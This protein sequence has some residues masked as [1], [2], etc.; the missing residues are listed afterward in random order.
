MQRVRNYMFFP[1]G[2]SMF[3]QD[4]FSCK[5][6]AETKVRKVN[7]LFPLEPL[8]FQRHSILC[9]VRSF[10]LE[11]CLAKCFQAGMWEALFCPCDH[12]SGRGTEKETDG[13]SLVPGKLYKYT[14]TGKPRHVQNFKKFCILILM[15]RLRMKIFCIRVE[16][17]AHDR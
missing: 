6:R 15:F 9:T 16:N 2:S 12:C 1:S 4:P 5:S 3:A 7:Y 8:Y 11:G 13:S 10:L 17:L 14:L